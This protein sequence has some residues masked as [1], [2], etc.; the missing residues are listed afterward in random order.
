ML[1]T[2]EVNYSNKG[3]YTRQI[4]DQEKVSFQK[5]KTFLFEQIAQYLYYTHK[6]YNQIMIQK[7]W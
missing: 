3:Y 4:E 6:I 2:Q 5:F 7:S 1:S